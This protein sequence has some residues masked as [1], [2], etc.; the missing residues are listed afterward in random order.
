ME[1]NNMTYEVEET[2][3]VEVTDLVPEAEDSEKSGIGAGEIALGALALVGGVFVVKKTY[4]GAKWVAGKVKSGY[5]AAK[6]KHEA[7]KAEKAAKKA[8]KAEATEEAKEEL[9]EEK[10]EGEG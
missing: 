10:S 4:D 6:E 7:K 9:P 1:D 3:D 2:M 5:E 8:A